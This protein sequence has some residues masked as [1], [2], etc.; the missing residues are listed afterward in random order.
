MG[1]HR[2]QSMSWIRAFRSRAR[3]FPVLMASLLFLVACGGG[4]SSSGNRD[5]PESELSAPSGFSATAGDARVVLDWSGVPGATSYNLYHSTSPGTASSGQLISGITGDTYTHTELTNN[6]TYY[7]VVR[8]VGTADAESEPSPEVSATPLDGTPATDSLLN[9][10][11]LAG[12]EDSET[13]YSFEVPNGAVSLLVRT[14][15]GTGDV[16]L[17][18]VGPGSEECTGLEFGNTESCEFTDPAPGGWEAYLLGWEAYQGVQLEVLIQTDTAEENDNPEDGIT[19]PT[20]LTASAGSSEVVLNWSSVAD[21][22]EY[23]V[24]VSES[25]DI[26]PDSGASYDIDL[27]TC[28]ATAATGY[29]VRNLTNGTQYFFVV[30]A[31]DGGVESAA[32]SEVTATPAAPVTAVR[33]LNDTGTDWCASVTD[34]NLSCPVAGFAGQDGDQGRDARVRAGDIDKIGGGVA[35]FDFTKLDAAGDPLAAS[36]T[37]WSCVRDNHT[38][39]IWEVKTNDDGF[40]DRDHVYTWYNP[41]SSS[42]GGWAGSETSSLCTRSSC[43]TLSYVQEVN[44]QN[45]CGAGDW[46]MPTRNELLGIVY[47][48]QYVE[49]ESNPAI[50]QDYFRNAPIFSEWY[51]SSSPHTGSSSGNVAWTVNFND[52]SA[53]DGGKGSSRHIRLV[54]TGQ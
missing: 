51:W 53:T 35:G 28:I 19:S 46:R 37:Q 14:S 23:C 48:D 41:D 32:S 47:N 18:V 7:Y 9:E 43:N 54:R 50:D 42:N 3:V 24:Y 52:G 1:L 27:S 38:G 20:G 2:L 34:A 49:G 21:A 13:R 4:G 44:A 11:D 10:A 45:L 25:A 39:L 8:A 33:P 40:R 29:T 26:H 5:E 31:K 36:A 15:G 12:A 6:T 22:D 30:T 16:D 17:V